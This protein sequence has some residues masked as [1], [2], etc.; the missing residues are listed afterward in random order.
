MAHAAAR[1]RGAAG[2]E[3][4]DRLFGSG[5]LQVLGTLDLGVAADLA[6]HD[7]A[8]GLGIPHEHFQALDEV[9]AVHRIAADADAGRL[10]EANRRG[11]RHG[12]I[13]ER[14]RARDDADLAALVDVSRHD[15]DLALA[16]RDD[17]RAVRPD[18]ARFRAGQRALD[19]HH[20]DHGNAFG[21]ADH[22]RDLRIDRLEDRVSRERRRH[23]D[24]AG[25]A[26]GLR[27]GLGHGV[28]HRQVE[29]RG[30]AFAGRH[31]AH[32]LGAVGDRLLGMEG[33]LAAGDA[34]ADHLGVLVDEDGHQLDS[35]TALTIFSAASARFS[36][37]VILRP[38][39]FRI[40][41]P[42]STFVP[43]SRT[44]S[45]TCRLTSRAAAT[46]PSAITSQRMMPPKMF[47]RMPSTLGSLRMILN[48]AVTRSLVAPPPT[49]RKLAG[50]EP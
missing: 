50:A 20:V 7:D 38:E 11:L 10:P 33:A 8:F 26:A 32:H 41:L 24:H 37:E 27:H 3:A 45:G 12:F 49:S 4:D 34:L 22:Q 31:A 42:R 44:T 18:Q 39:S 23:V 1:W 28:E 21:D 40:F 30:A 14:A 17:A 29:M 36:A 13:C 25:I 16:R 35:L 46:T 43:S 9:G 19:A 15:A 5:S 48:A 47:T 6:D 2:D